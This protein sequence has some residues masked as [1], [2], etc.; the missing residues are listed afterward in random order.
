M[1]MLS[2]HFY[3]MCP[4]A[5]LLLLL[6]P[7]VVIVYLRLQK[8]QWQQ[9]FRFSPFSVLEHLER[10]PS[11]LKRLALPLIALLVLVCLIAAVARPTL[12]HKVATKSVDMMLVMDI[13]LSMMATDIQP[14]RI[15]AARDAAAHFVESLPDDVRIGL[16]LFAGDN[17]VVSPPTR[18]H[19]QVVAYLNDLSKDRLQQQTQIGSAIQAGLS[20]LTLSS[21]EQRDQNS[22]KKLQNQSQK[23][24]ILMSD[25]DS[26]AGYPWTVAATHARDQNV[27]IDTVGIGGAE[28]TTIAYQGLQLPVSFDESTLRQIA[29]MA[30]GEY[31]R[32]F[33]GRDFKTVYDR[34]R[35]K[36][37]HY[38]DQPEELS[39]VLALLALL[40]M[41]VGGLLQTLWIRHL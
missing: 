31:F 33:T 35:E 37:I 39:W 29:Q 28:P 6:L 19:R 38:E 34:V 16:E 4:Q 25:G 5:F 2:S 15:T 26:Q 8:R 21:E 10:N 17:W 41:L 3:W 32:V 30:G 11:P 27:V 20:V 9:A 22:A 40:L 23:V 18:D 14:D 7:V 12:V 24:M 1:C 13:S 36:S